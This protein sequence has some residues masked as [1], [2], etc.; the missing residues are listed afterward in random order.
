MD[1]PMNGNKYEVEG[2]EEAQNIRK[3]VLGGKTCY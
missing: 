3:K 1:G 2:K